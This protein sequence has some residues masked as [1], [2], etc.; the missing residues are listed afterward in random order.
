MLRVEAGTSTGG[1]SGGK[2]LR[3]EERNITF[4]FLG[5]L[6]MGSVF[7]F[8]LT[9]NE[10]IIPVSARQGLVGASYD[11]GYILYTEPNVTGSVAFSSTYDTPAYEFTSPEEEQQARA[12]ATECLIVFGEMFNGL[13][14]SDGK[15]RVRNG[16]DELSL[17]DFGY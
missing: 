8:E 1:S 7:A 17:H 6:A 16:V 4:K 15:I 2:S 14:K 3:D 11:T 10:R 12:I 9:W 13:S 5:T